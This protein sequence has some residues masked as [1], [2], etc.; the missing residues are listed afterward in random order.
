VLVNENFP[1]PA[2]QVLRDRGVDVVAVADTMQG[3]SDE[4]VLEAARAQD[5]WLVTF[6]RDYG[7]L[8]FKEGRACPTAILYLRQE[9]YPPAHAADLVLRALASPADAEG[10]FVVIGQHTVRRR[11]LPTTTR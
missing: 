7:E 9:T 6:D 10:F 8:V 3:A 4:Q 1:V 2:L 11:P 5:R